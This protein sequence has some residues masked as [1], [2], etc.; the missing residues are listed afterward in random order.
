MKKK[1]N[2]TKKSIFSGSSRDSGPSESEI[3]AAK[4]QKVIVQEAAQQAEAYLMKNQPDT[5]MRGWSDFAGTDS[6]ASENEKEAAKKQ[7]KMVKE[8]ADLVE[9][10]LVKGQKSYVK[11]KKKK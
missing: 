8:T 3:E 11:S 2:R 1:K 10:Y 4:N 9:D 7:H 5:S 6:N